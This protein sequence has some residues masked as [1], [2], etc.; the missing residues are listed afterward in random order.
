[1][2]GALFLQRRAAAGR[3]ESGRPR[4]LLHG[5]STGP[6]GAAGSQNSCLLKNRL[7]GWSCPFHSRPR[8]A[9]IDPRVLPFLKTESQAD[10]RE[11]HTGHPGF[12]LLPSSL[13][14]GC[15]GGWLLFAQAE[16]CRVVT[17]L[18]TSAPRHHWGTPQAPACPGQGQ[19]GH[20]GRYPR[21]LWGGM[22]AG[23]PA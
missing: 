3:A 6:S 2:N 12:F 5:K 17:A 15:S 7:L 16:R 1:M 13:L 11:P 4:P 14:P 10:A 19:Q 20:R 23:H 8:P 21:G 9:A 22:W 18:G